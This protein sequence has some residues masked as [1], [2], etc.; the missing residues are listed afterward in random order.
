M[1]AD[2]LRRAIEA[3]PRNDLARVASAL[4][5]AYAAGQVTEDEASRLSELIEAKRV[6]PPP[7]P[8]PRLKPGSRPRTPE[9]LARRRRWAAGGLLPPALACRFTAAETAVLAVVAAEAR[10]RGDCRLALDHLAALAGVSRTTAKNALKEAQRLGLVRI[11][12][13]RLTAW[14]N[15][16]NVVT[17]TSPEWQSWLRLRPKGGGVKT[18]TR[19]HTKIYKQTPTGAAEP[20]KSCRRQGPGRFSTTNRRPAG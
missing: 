13:R 7:P 4:W 11:E 8:R 6:L 20:L 17:I 18:A 10:R 2:Q 3:S 19:T 5:K 12:E 1:F 15:D 14:R 9:S 16:T